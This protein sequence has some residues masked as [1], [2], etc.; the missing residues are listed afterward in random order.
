MLAPMINAPG[1]LGD[2]NFMIDALATRDRKEARKSA[3]LFFGINERRKDIEHSM[4]QEAIAMLPEDPSQLPRFICLMGEAFQEQWGR[5]SGF[6]KGVVGIVCQRLVD[7]YLRP[8]GIFANYGGFASGSFRSIE[9]YDMIANLKSQGIEEEFEKV[10]GHP[11]AAGGS[12]LARN[13]QRLAEKLDRS[14]TRDFGAEYSPPTWKADA[15]CSLRDL[16]PRAVAELRRF[17]P[18]GRENPEPEVIIENLFVDG[19]P[20]VIGKHRNHLRVQLTDGQRSV[21]AIFWRRTEHEYLREGQRVHV[22]ATPTLS[23]NGQAVQLT[24]K[25]PIHPSEVGKR[26]WMGDQA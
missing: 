14:V 18:F 12:I 10:G 8:A 5:M 19:P 13:H 7:L 22:L 6:H 15:I 3:E 9:G 4:L 17:E 26:L 24:I 2:A 20:R 25:N 16:T 1:R 23:P 11:A 21:E